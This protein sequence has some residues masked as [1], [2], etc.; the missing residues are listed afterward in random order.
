[1]R[2]FL[3]F[4]KNEKLLPL[5][6]SVAFF[7]RLVYSFFIFPRIGDALYWRGV[8]DGYDEIARNMLGGHGFVMM[9]GRPENLLIPPGYA[10]FLAGLYSLFGV[11]MA[12]GARLW[13]AQAALDALTCGALYAVGALLIRDRRVGLF[14]AAAWALYPQMIVYSARIAPEVLF[15]LLFLLLFVA[16]HALETRGGAGRA[17]LAGATWGALVLTKEKVILLPA[18]LLARLAWV[19]LRGDAAA[20]AEGGAATPPRARSRASRL[21]LE[22]ALFVVAALVVIGPW[23]VRGYRLTGGLVPITLRGGRALDQGMKRDIG[24]ADTQMIDGFERFYMVGGGRNPT[25]DTLSV[26]E[27]EEQIRNMSAREASRLET[28][29]GEIARS[30]FTFLRRTAVRAAAYWYWGQPRVVLGNALI[31]IPLVLLAIVGLWLTRRTSYAPVAALLI[32]YMNVIH[33][34]TVVRMRY[35]LPVMTLVML[36]AAVAIVRLWERRQDASSRR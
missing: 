4:V 2:A 16:W 7:A 5:V 13:I 23:L 25:Y 14:A 11:E 30:P 20:P 33:A 18:L 19:R 10:Y 32:L 35:S 8:D 29:L 12:E 34:M 15:T 31:N 36:L 1:M 27:R 21:A 6:V 22:S 9:P 17:L 26:E 24:G 3:H 28:T